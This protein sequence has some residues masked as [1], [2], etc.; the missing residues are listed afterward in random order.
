MDMQDWRAFSIIMCDL[1]FL[2]QKIDKHGVQSII[3]VYEQA[4]VTLEKEGAVTSQLQDYRN[5]VTAQA[6]RLEVPA[7]PLLT[8]MHVARALNMPIATLWRQKPN[9]GGAVT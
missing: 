3:Q 1:R 9:T 2:V 7:T 5:F 6:A 4:W 8:R